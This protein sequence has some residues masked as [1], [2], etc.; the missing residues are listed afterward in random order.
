MLSAPTADWRDWRKE[1]S[2]NILKWESLM[3]KIDRWNLYVYTNSHNTGITSKWT[4]KFKNLL[5]KT[6]SKTFLKIF[7]L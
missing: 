3:H 2:Q 5:R 1:E 6:R 4:R 7:R